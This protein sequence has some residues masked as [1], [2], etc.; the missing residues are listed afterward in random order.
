MD[1]S[2]VKSLDIQPTEDK[3]ALETLIPRRKV[4]VANP[5]N[6]SISNGAATGN[7]NGSVTKRLASEI[8]ELGS[9]LAKRP[10]RQS[11]DSIEMKGTNGKAAEPI[12]VGDNGAILIDDD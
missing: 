9:P 11:N 2:S 3:E 6:G 1:G 7:L 10:R 4:P 8:T 12:V 5:V